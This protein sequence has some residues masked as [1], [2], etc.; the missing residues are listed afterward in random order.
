MSKKKSKR[1]IG[2]GL[3][4]FSITAIGLWLLFRPITAIKIAIIAAAS[5][6]V[7]K[8]VGAMSTGLDLTTHNRQDQQPEKEYE[9]LG[10]SETGDANADKVIAE[11]RAYL[12][13]IREANNA[14]PDAD[15]TRKLYQLENKCV[16]IFKTV[17]ERP[18]K[19]GQI[20]KF[21]NYYLPTTLK[22][23]NSYRTMQ[24]RG[25]SY[26]EMVRAKE[27]LHR[28]M[29]MVLTASQKQLDN[30]YKDTMLDV[31]TDIDVLEQMLKR[32]GFAE[33]DFSRE[34]IN[35]RTAAAAQWGD[36]DVPTLNVSEDNNDSFQSYYQQK[37]RSN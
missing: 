15:V 32:D 27:T 22:M 20:R 21:M 36:S 17:E 28:G 35:A 12:Q 9:E 33:G 37:G 2:S 23:L 26:G 8:A 30:L 25:I 13:A 6:A 1:E 14:I 24:D 7:G 19:A 11:G 29:D 3:S 18:A 10:T 16:Q 4:G 34:T 31:S 5:F